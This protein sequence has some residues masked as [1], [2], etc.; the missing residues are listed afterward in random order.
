MSTSHQ[1]AYAD[2]IL[3]PA[4]GNPTFLRTVD[5]DL[6]TKSYAAFANASVEIVPDVRLSGGIRYTH[7]TKDYFRTTTTSS[8]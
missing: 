2:D 7:E 5:D 1:E 3:G 6:T 4:F 8:T